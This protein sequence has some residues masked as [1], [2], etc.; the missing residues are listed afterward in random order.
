MLPVSILSTISFPYGHPVV[1]R[2]S[3]TTSRNFCTFLYLPFNFT[4]QKTVPV[5]DV[6]YAVSLPSLYCLQ[7]IRLLL[8]FLQY[9]F[10]HMISPTD[11]IYPSPA[12]QFKIFQVLIY[13][14][15]CLIFSTIQSYIPNKSLYRTLP[16]FFLKLSPN[17]WWK[18]SFLLSNVMAILDSISL[19]HLASFSYH[20]TKILEIFTF[21]SCI[22]SIVISSDSSCLEIFI[23][24]IFPH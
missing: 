7:D 3:S 14:P 10:S 6:T 2:S 1:A 19:V 11:L 15:K 18:I 20:A 23:T 17:F 4:F 12:P 24:S 9:L 22:L 16:S 21:F 13:F 8:D 5:Q